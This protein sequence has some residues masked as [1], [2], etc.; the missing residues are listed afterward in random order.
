MERH[1]LRLILLDSICNSRKKNKK[2]IRNKHARVVLKIYKSAQLT[3]YGTVRSIKQWDN[4]FQGKIPS[5]MERDS[6]LVGFTR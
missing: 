3:R 1:L 2:G 6:Q 4:H 5:S